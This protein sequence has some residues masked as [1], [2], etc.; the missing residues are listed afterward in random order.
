[1]PLISYSCLCKGAYELPERLPPEYDAGER[2]GFIQKMA[3]EKGVNASALVISWLTNLY[4][5]EGYPRVIPLFS[6][7]Y[8]HLMEN[9]RGLE[10]ELTR[11][12][13]D[14]MNKVH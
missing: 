11:E 6:A 12:E 3:K 10:I 7:N 5:C 13:L 9:L 8:E 14:L 1:M 4:R 2:L